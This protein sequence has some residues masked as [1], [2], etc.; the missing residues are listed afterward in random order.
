V[1]EAGGTFAHHHGVGRSKA[2]LLAADL[3]HGLPVV[4]D[5]QRAFDPQGVMN[6]GNLR[7]APDP[8]AFATG[9]PPAG[10]HATKERHGSHGISANGAPIALD[11]ESH[12]VD[13][14]GEATLRDVEAA[15]AGHGFTL[16]IASDE[17]MGMD[18]ATWIAKGGPGHRS[19]WR[20]PV[21]HVVAGF[22]FRLEGGRSFAIGPSPRRSTGP[23]LLAIAWGQEGR[24]GRVEQAWLRVHRIGVPR[25]TRAPFEPPDAPAVSPEE[26]AL[27]SA[28]ERHLTQAATKA[29]DPPGHAGED[30][31]PIAP[32]PLRG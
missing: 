29:R 8:R 18:V 24:F 26:D 6:P 16:D 9:A 7:V 11:G 13:S 2:P 21:D 17:A 5:L 12:L 27:W 19:T 25:A 15:L 20:D 22:S 23:D 1:H 31:T 4:R 14:A 10:A 28:F 3:G 32:R 30:E